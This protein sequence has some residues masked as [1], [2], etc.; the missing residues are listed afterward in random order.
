[1]LQASKQSLPR[2]SGQ[3]RPS[4][5]PAWR[6]DVCCFRRGPRGA[7]CDAWQGLLA[8]ND[9]KRAPDNRRK[10]RLYSI[11]PSQSR[12]ALPSVEHFVSCH[13]DCSLLFNTAVFCIQIGAFFWLLTR[14][15]ARQMGLSRDAA[16]ASTPR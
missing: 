16:P 1:M 6:R 11:Q 12:R 9:R 4:G 14:L 8:D 7:G 13:P 2:I 5:L 10:I 3:L 15:R